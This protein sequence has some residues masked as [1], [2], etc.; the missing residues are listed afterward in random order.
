MLAGCASLLCKTCNKHRPESDFSKHKS[1]V[2]GFDTSRC[3]PCKKARADWAKVPLEKRIY[4]R[5]KSRAKK[6]GRDFDISLE[7]I[8]IPNRCPVLNVEFVYGDPDWTYSI[9]RLDNSKGYV[10]GNIIIVSNRANKLKNNATK[11]ELQNVLDF[12]FN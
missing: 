12:Y 4:N 10:K 6:M 3:K 11:E 2:G 7:D 1:C 9:D 5:A 8:V